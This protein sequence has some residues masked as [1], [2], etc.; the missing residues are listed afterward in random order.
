MSL[1][2]IPSLGGDAAGEDKRRRMVWDKEVWSN[3]A[4]KE[5]QTGTGRR[6]RAREVGQTSRVYRVGERG[7]WRKRVTRER[8][9][10]EGWAGWGTNSSQ[11]EKQELQ[12][13]RGGK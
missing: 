4:T 1:R 3:N 5:W 10:V 2:C 9:G 8:D 12:E 7:G 6:R 11:G 13:S